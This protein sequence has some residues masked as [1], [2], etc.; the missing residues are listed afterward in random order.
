MTHVPIG[1]FPFGEK[2]LKEDKVAEYKE[3]M[4]GFFLALIEL[5]C[6]IYI[7]ERFMAF[8]YDLFAEGRT[9][10]GFFFQLTVANFLKAS[11]LLITRL[12]TDQGSDV[13]TLPKFRNGLRQMVKTEHQSDIQERLKA[14]RFDQRTKELLEKARNLRDTRI[15]HFIHDSAQ[16]GMT[17]LEIKALR[18]E[19]NTLLQAL[20]FDAE[21][22][23]LPFS[24]QKQRA[25][26]D[27]VLDSVANGSELLNMSEH[28]PLCWQ[29]RRPGFTDEEIYMINAYRV[30]FG[31][32]E[33]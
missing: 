3:Q 7:V 15:A 12:A 14:L 5:N 9:S 26:V 21:Y 23:M 30:K 18:D 24:Y 22:F 31:L 20:S 19:L 25:D 17:L 32:P 6:N 29:H 1:V 4:K 11:I 27:W 8:P 2:V 28:D 13:R 16:E 33:V 10:D